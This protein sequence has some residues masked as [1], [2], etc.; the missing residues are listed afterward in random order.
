MLAMKK[1]A[2]SVRTQFGLFGARG[3]LKRALLAFP[4]VNC[5]FE[6]S[7]PHYSQKIFLRLGT[8]D[9]ASFKQVFVDNQYGLDLSTNPSIIVDAGA[10]V[11]MSAAYYSLR[12]PSA[13][14]VAVEPGPSNFDVL[15][16]NA[17]L[18][19][20]IIPIHAALWNHEGTVRIQNPG[21]G[22]WGMRVSEDNTSSGTDIRSVTVPALL[23]QL[24]IDRIDL[25]KIDVEGA[26][27]E[28]FQDAAAWIDRVGVICVELHDHFRLG[29]SNTFDAAT[30]GFPIRWRHGELHCVAREGLIARDMP[31]KQEPRRKCR[32]G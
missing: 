32:G 2:D 31:E 9:V 26:E 20:K 1:V 21:T 18:F 27:C 7:I 6:A 10:N 15:S 11:G 14:I 25:L 8:S 17:K 19:P 4:G 29:C 22:N 24:G 16:R 12:Y 3:L 5:E 13:T 28:I 30:A 23:K